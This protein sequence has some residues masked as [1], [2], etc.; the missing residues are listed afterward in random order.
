MAD[1]FPKP[2]E[3]ED[4][5]PTS[6]GWMATF[7]DM[8]TLLMSFFILI[9]SFSTME[10]DKFKLAMGSLK[11]AFGVLGVQKSLRPDQSWFSPSSNGASSA[12]ERSIL[13]HV[14]RLR[15]IIEQNDL[16]EKVDVEMA[17]GEVFVQIKDNML[18]YPGSGKLQP[19]Y[20]K[21]LSLIAKMFF[22]DVEQI[23]VEGHTDDIPI[24]T[25]DYPSNWDL[26][27]ERALNVLRYFVNEEKI[28]PAKLVAAGY[29]EHKPLV[30]NNSPENRAKNRRVV[31]RMKI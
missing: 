8:M 7:A 27:F 30:P 11:G 16:S 18:F 2:P 28:D 19:N 22:K 12:R 6:P 1:E 9:M 15:N 26:S 29:G 5:M 14:Q 21:L 10:V 13:E 31:L 3:D 20:L 23:L 25:D 24:H 4:D 17:D